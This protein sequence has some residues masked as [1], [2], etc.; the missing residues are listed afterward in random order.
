MLPIMYSD[1]I[2]GKTLEDWLRMTPSR[3]DCAK[4]LSTEAVFARQ[5]RRHKQA[6]TAAVSASGGGGGGGT[7]KQQ[8]RLLL[9]VST[10]F[11]GSSDCD[12]TQQR[13]Y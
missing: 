6:T 2:R 12:S 13:R 8:R 4:A 11:A 9:A 1:T 5:Q 7:S 10:V 3:A